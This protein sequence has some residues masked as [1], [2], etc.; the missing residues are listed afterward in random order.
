MCRHCGKKPANRPRG[1]CW[2]C[3]YT[4]G[5]KDRYPSTSK[6]AVRGLGNGCF[7]SRPASHPCPH[8]IG[9]EGRIQTMQERANRGESM[10]HP[11]DCRDVQLREGGEPCRD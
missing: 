4:P 6:H 3:Y 11:A 8:P 5:V 1:L 9:S 2:P 7:A 10:Y